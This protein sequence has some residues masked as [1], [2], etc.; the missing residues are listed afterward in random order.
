MGLQGQGAGDRAWY[1]S[2]VLH[3]ALF[4]SHRWI[5]LVGARGENGFSRFLL[6]GAGNACLPSSVSLRRHT[7]NDLSCIPGFCQISAFTLCPSCPP[8]KPCNTAVFYLG[9]GCISKSHT[10]ETPGCRPTPILWRRVSCSCGWCWLVP[11]DS[12]ETAEWFGVYG[13]LQHTARARVCC[14]QRVSLFLC[15]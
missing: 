4:S 6:S 10:S 14:P 3:W 15:W 2:S 7:N 5:K 9:H 11:D 1:S 13:K 8:A 12:R